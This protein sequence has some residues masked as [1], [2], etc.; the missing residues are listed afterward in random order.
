MG[1]AMRVQDAADQALQKI[2][3]LNQQPELPAQSLLQ[4]WQQ[5]VAASSD[6]PAF[7]C[8]GQTLSYTEVD[9]LADHAAAY[10]HHQFNLQPGDRIAV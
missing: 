10:F 4:L 3:L 9:Q 8:L 5:A 7:T 6:L 1:K 2:G